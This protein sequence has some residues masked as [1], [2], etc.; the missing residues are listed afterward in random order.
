MATTTA[1]TR[2][3]R[4]I[5]GML[6][7]LFNDEYSILLGRII[8]QYVKSLSFSIQGQRFPFDPTIQYSQHTKRPYLEA[9]CAFVV[10]I[11]IVE[12]DHPS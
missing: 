12:L 5:R 6:A 7:G 10:P 3:N 9:A 11:A 2:E 4:M 1:F 8:S